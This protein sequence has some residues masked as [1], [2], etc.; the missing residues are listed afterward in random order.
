MYVLLVYGLV[1]RLYDNKINLDM[2][3]FLPLPSI[4]GLLLKKIQKYFKYFVGISSTNTNE[5]SLVQ[6]GEQSGSKGLLH[7]LNATMIPTKVS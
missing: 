6:L 3:I 7:T 4:C 1:T 5:T 2:Y